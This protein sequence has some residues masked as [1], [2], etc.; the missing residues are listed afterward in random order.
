MQKINSLSTQF[1][2]PS[3]CF[4]ILKTL[5]SRNKEVL[6]KRF[7][8]KNGSAQTLQE[9]GD[10]YGIT[11]ERVRQIEKESLSRLAPLREERNLQNLFAYFS[12][13]L[14]SQGEL[15]REDKILADLGGQNQQNNVYFLLTL[16]EPFYRF[17][18]DEDVYS[19]WA[20]QEDIHQSLK[21]ALQKMI[22]KLEQEE[23]PLPQEHLFSDIAETPSEFL[24]SAVEIAKNIEQGPLGGF[25][26]VFWPD[27]KPRGVKDVA[28][29]V[30]QK[31]QKPLHF[32]QIAEV[33][34]GF[35]ALSRTRPVLSQ[36]IHNEL[37][38]DPRFVLVG[39]GIYALKEWGY[40]EGIVRKVIIDILK[41][42]KNGLTKDEIVQAVLNQRLVKPNTILLNLHNKRYFTRD[43][44]GRYNVK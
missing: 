43:E 12:D 26:L 33:A 30:L 11:R 35:D 2:Y 38:R 20:L 10:N 8:L 14:K 39:R 32:R 4:G 1:N 29:L 16:G 41:A 40:N 13:Y 27:I 18:E 15:K 28:Y 9:I 34:N 24:I 42:Q 31:T 6:E 25:G 17:P 37:I 7:G 5:P 44:Q 21:S 36:T 3:I 19:F 22:A 23:K